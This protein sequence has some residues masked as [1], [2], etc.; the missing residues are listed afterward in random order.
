M[1]ASG[2]TICESNFAIV[3]PSQ[4]LKPVAQL[5]HIT[6]RELIRLRQAH[7]HADAPDALGLLR[8][9]CER[10]SGCRSHDQRDELS[11][12]HAS[13]PRLCGLSGRCAARSAYH[14]EDGRSL[15]TPEMF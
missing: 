13:M 14:G 12:L 4:L 6:L 15:G 11:P 9:R 3:C 5:A 2:V 8:A 7:E 10:P 1:V